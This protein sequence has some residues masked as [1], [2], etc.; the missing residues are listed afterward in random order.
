MIIGFTKTKTYRSKFLLSKWFF[1]RWYSPFKSFK[2]KERMSY[3]YELQTSIKE[4]FEEK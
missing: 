1:F 2:T 3:V 4:S